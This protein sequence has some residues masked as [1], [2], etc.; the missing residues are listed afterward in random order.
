MILPSGCHA[1]LES[2]RPPLIIRTRTAHVSL[3]L[4]L[5]LSTELYRT[6]LNLWPQKIAVQGIIHVGIVG[7]V[8]CNVD[9]IMLKKIKD[10]GRVTYLCAVPINF[11]P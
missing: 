8:E 4:S 1:K 2:I 3:S 6:C 7:A 11:I 5:S 9:V 10:V